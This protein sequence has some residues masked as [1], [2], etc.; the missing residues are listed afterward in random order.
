MAVA[1]TAGDWP[2]PVGRA[3]KLAEGFVRK[4]VDLHLVLVF[5][6][7]WVP[8]LYDPL[9]SDGAALDSAE[10]PASLTA[11][12]SGD[13]PIEA[14]L[15]LEPES[16]PAVWDIV[17][18]RYLYQMMGSTH[19]SDCHHGPCCSDGN[20]ASAATCTIASSAIASRATSGGALPTATGGGRCWDIDGALNSSIPGGFP[21]GCGFSTYI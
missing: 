1:A 6:I 2:V 13:A 9:L 21:P 4:P 14:G 18:L 3:V 20:G 8:L 15:G 19:H 7:G 5:E 12:D 11:D 16:G 17:S 10:A